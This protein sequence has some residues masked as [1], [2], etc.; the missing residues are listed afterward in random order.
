ML[1]NFK[2]HKH[3]VINLQCY[4]YLKLASSAWRSEIKGNNWL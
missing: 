3:T 2:N 1:S 4:L